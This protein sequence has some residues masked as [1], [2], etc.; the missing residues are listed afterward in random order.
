MQD[1]LFQR[2]MTS[3][4]S[5]LVMEAREAT[6]L[7][8]PVVENWIRNHRSFVHADTKNKL[9]TSK[10]LTAYNIFRSDF[11][12]QGG[13]LQDI[14]GRWATISEDKK[15]ELR[16]EAEQCNNSLEFDKDRPMKIKRQMNV[17]GIM[18]SMHSK[19]IQ[20][21]KLGVESSILLHNPMDLDKLVHQIGSKRGKEFLEAQG[22]I[23]QHLLV[24]YLF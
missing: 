23:S 3:R 7:S 4:G 20:L 11:M 13:S 19:M 6:G 9:H 15:E 21:E 17:K 18:R 24:Q 12:Q 8:Q 22:V 14:A 1:N 5:S 10:R 16:K 2:G